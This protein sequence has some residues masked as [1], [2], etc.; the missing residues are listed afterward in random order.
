MVVI[1]C[2][3]YIGTEGSR[4]SVRLPGTPEKTCP[5]T[6]P[7]EGE[8][9]PWNVDLIGCEISFIDLGSCCLISSYIRSF[10]D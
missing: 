10:S 7:G 3:L 8:V 1:G 5:E 4:V 2:V 6:M 9:G